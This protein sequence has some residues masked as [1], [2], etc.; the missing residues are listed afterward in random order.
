MIQ[1]ATIGAGSLTMKWAILFTLPMVANNTTT[2][3]KQQDYLQQ[4]NLN[5]LQFK[6]GSLPLM[7]LSFGVKQKQLN[8]NGSAAVVNLDRLAK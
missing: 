5:G 6:M 7:A 4:L 2:F 8:G 3:A 1:T